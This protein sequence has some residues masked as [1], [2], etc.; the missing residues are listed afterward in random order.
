VKERLRHQG[1]LPRTSTFIPKEKEADAIRYNPGP[2]EAPL[3][4]R[5][6][7]A[8]LGGWIGGPESTAGKN[9]GDWGGGDLDLSQCQAFCF[10]A[11]LTV[12]LQLLIAGPCLEAMAGAIKRLQSFGGFFGHSE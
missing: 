9:G 11:L 12:S 3:A 5:R 2:K 1:K 4:R 7:G 10:A 8:G 6:G